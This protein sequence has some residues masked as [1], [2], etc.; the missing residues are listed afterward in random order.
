MAPDKGAG[1]SR[2]RVPSV[3]AFHPER[4]LGSSSC[5]SVHQRATSRRCRS[6]AAADGRS[7]H[8]DDVARPRAGVYGDN[9]VIAYSLRHEQLEPRI[10]AEED[11]EDDKAS[12]KPSPRLRSPAASITSGRTDS[13]RRLA[14][15]G[16][17]G[18]EASPGGAEDQR[19]PACST[20]TPTGVAR[21]GGGFTRTR[22]SPKRIVRAER[23]RRGQVA[24][25]RQFGWYV[26]G[27]TTSFACRRRRCRSPVHGATSSTTRRSKPSGYARNPANDIDGDGGVASNR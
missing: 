4:G 14:F 13:R 11:R 8:P 3:H 27:P 12:Q 21:G 7:H 22:R 6:R 15:S 5:R 18:R 25:S 23:T 1:R 24:G 20:S 17:T 19:G 2:V 26:R 9:G 10:D 16:D